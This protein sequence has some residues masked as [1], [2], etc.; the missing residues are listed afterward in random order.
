MKTIGLIL[1]LFI[2][3]NNSSLREI[4]GETMGTYYV[5]RYFSSVDEKS[6][7]EK[8]DQRLIEFNN[9][10]STYIKTS[11]LSKINQ[12]N[13]SKEI[14]LSNE[15]YDVIKLSESISL[16]SNGAFDITVGP[17]V[18]AYG[19]GPNK[20][21][22]EP[23][24]EDLIKLKKLVGMDKFSLNNNILKKKNK[25]VYIDLSAI[26]KGAGVDAV[27]LLLK[28]IGIKNALVEIGGEVRSLDGKI[29]GEPWR[30]GIEG[31]S[32]NLGESIQKIV[33][34][35]NKSIATSGSYRNFIKFGDRIF[36]HTIDPRTAKPI[37]H[38]LISVS[39]ILDTCAEADGWA[40][41]LMVLGEEEGKKVAEKY[42]IPAYFLTKK[43]DTINEVFTHN[44]SEYF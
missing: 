3:C 37:F 38:N 15:L 17:I 29:S 26:A 13:E 30:V 42:K 34:L 20:K 12:E 18:N 24:N 39:V 14:I 35:K 19:F 28:E 27:V 33:K 9:I 40:T 22:N 7:K 1:L 4:K 11:E 5:V 23:K 8:I 32:K 43:G 16:K 6:L 25:D 31:P 10:F 2:S 36:S 21:V 41:A 44:M